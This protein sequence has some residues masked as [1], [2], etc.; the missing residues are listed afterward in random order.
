MADNITGKDFSNASITLASKDLSGVQIPKAINVDLAGN[1]I[2]AVAASAALAAVNAAVSIV[3]TGQSAW[4]VQVEGTWVG[5]I[6]FQGTVDGTNWKPI[7]GALAGIGTV[8][9]STTA[10]AIFRGNCAGLTSVRAIMT[11]FTSGSAT[12][13]IVAGAGVGAIFDN[14]PSLMQ[15]RDAATGAA[16]D[17]GNTPIFAD[18]EGRLK[19]NLKTGVSTPALSA[20]VSLPLDVTV[21][22]GSIASGSAV[23]NLELLTNTASGWFD[24]Q[25]YH[26]ASIQIQTGAGISAGVLTFEQTND[27]AVSPAGN[28][29]RVFDD[30]II[31]NAAATSMT[32][33]ASTTKTFYASLTSRYFR[34]R[35]STAVAGGTVQVV[36]SFSQLPLPITVVDTEL[37]AAALPAD[38]T[39]GP[40]NPGVTAMQQLFNGASYDRERNNVSISVEASSAKT[41][42][43]NSAAA[44]VNFNAKGV[45]LFLNISAV[46]GTSPTLVLKVQEQDPVSAAWFD[47]AGATTAALSISG[48]TKLEIYPGIPA[49]ANV[50]VNNALARV[51]RLVW[52]ITGTTPSFTFSVGAQYIN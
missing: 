5:T 42:N 35:V 36:G 31:G 49:V 32:L 26:S 21:T 17:G 6:A 15:R 44:I 52:T 8:D 3:I 46:S 28:L 45:K 14:G 1:Q 40:V 25:N 38:G 33:A 37:G 16:A 51:W 9:T 27:T 13:T 20:P 30:A 4:S 10:N 11:A 18:S 29:Q 34:V 41:A 23:L 24:A 7:L 12:A 48:L 43:G 2:A 39:G 47:L 50:S 22:G 19:V